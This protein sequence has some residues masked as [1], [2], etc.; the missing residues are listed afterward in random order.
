MAGAIGVCVARWWARWLVEVH[1]TA[2]EFD[3]WGRAGDGDRDGV[4]RWG[5]WWRLPS[6]CSPT[7]AR[8]TRSTWRWSCRRRRWMSTAIWQ[9]D[10]LT[11][12]WRERAN[13]EKRQKR[14]LMEQCA[15]LKSYD[16]AKLQ[17]SV[18]GLVYMY[19]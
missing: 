2:A 9:R 12:W 19:V 17:E 18:N 7:C 10:S 15:L 1:G 11:L 16:T 4:Q 8:S 13:E 14:M 5:D 6:R 3:E